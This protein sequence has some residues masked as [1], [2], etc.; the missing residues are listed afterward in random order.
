MISVP[1]LAKKK[2]E[3]KTFVRGRFTDVHV[4][5]QIYELVIL[6]NATFLLIYWTGRCRSFVK[7]WLR[8]IMFALRSISINE[9]ELG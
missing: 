9:Y 2:N 3:K 1:I 6:K 5:F 4:L 8:F 7:R